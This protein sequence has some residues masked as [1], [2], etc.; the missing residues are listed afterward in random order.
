MAGP[1]LSGA[2]MRGRSRSL[3]PA[4]LAILL[5]AVPVRAWATDVVA[6]VSG[7]IGS[8][9]SMRVS[10]CTAEEYKPRTCRY[11]A[12][13]PARAGTMSIT[14]PN[15]APGRYAVIAH[16]DRDD[17]GRVKTNWLG[18]PVEGVGVSRNATGRFGPP[19]FD[20][21]AVDIGG[22]RMTFDIVLRQEPGG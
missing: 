4:A 10:V 7:I 16:H 1:D 19:G 3:A 22:D 15:V 2:L 12:H 6:Q 8:L 9:G 5:L 21:V 14:V 11:T 13:V 17:N 20:D 18:I